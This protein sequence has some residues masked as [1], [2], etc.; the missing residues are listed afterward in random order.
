VG[1]TRQGVDYDLLRITG[2]AKLNGT[3]AVN[4][5]AGATIT[6]ESDFEFMTY[7][8]HTGDFSSATAPAGSTF[9]TAPGPTSYG[10]VAGPAAPPSTTTTELQ[11]AQTV[12]TRDALVFSDRLNDLRTPNDNL[13]SSQSAE[14]D[15]QRDAIPECR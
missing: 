1:G 14:A 15:R 9:H 11:Q 13:G 10:V 4:I 3:L 5:P 12:T 7:A 2:N 6:P 8:S